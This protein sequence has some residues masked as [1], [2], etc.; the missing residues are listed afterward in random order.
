MT[1]MIIIRMILIINCFVFL[2]QTQSVFANDLENNRDLK[3][4]ATGRTLG[5]VV[6]S[7]AKQS[8]YEILISEDLLNLEVKGSFHDK[9]I[10]K[11]FNRLL[12]GYNIF[13][14][15]DT[16]KKELLVFTDI[17]N[18]KKVYSFRDQQART[19]NTDNKIKP[20][21]DMEVAPGITTSQVREMR[22]LYQEDIRTN[23]EEVLFGEG[24]IPLSDIKDGR[25][26]F[27]SSYN[28]G[29]TDIQ[30]APR[31]SLNQVEQARTDFKTSN[32]SSEVFFNE[33]KTMSEKNLVAL[34]R[35]FAEKVRTGKI[36]ITRDE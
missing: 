22:Q 11:L 20:D 25:D 15:L 29:T 21:N 33:G 3:I 23:K 4:E 27:R 12:R 31:V 14:I 19:D 30:V 5:E 34:R 9:D 10:E 16:E 6:E 17:R 32:D 13:Q 8:G 7:I 1:S 28:N 2:C 26:Q 36:V 35:E 24:N 18:T